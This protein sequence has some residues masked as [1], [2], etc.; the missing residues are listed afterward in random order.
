MKVFLPTFVA[1]LGL[2][3]A[4]LCSSKNATGESVVACPEKHCVHKSKADKCT[5]KPEATCKKEDSICCQNI[6]KKQKETSTTSTDCRITK[7]CRKAEGR[8]ISTD[9]S[10]LTSVVSGS[11]IKGCKCCK[12]KIKQKIS[13]QGTTSCKKRGGKCK[14]K[15]A[16][17][18]KRLRRASCG[19]S[20]VCCATKISSN[21][22]TRTTESCHRAGGHC[23]R[24]EEKCTSEVFK[25]NLCVGTLCDCCIDD[26]TPSDSV[27]GPEDDFVDYGDLYDSIDEVI[28]G[29]IS[30]ESV[31]NAV[32]VLNTDD[33]DELWE[34]D[35]GQ[36][37]HS[38]ESY[39]ND[40]S[41]T[42]EITPSLQNLNYTSCV[43]I[44]S[45]NST[46]IDA[47]NDSLINTS[48]NLNHA[49]VNTNKNDNTSNITVTT[50]ASATSINMNIT[51]PAAN[52]SLAKN[53]S[54]TVADG[55][56]TS[57]NF[58]SITGSS[59]STSFYTNGTLSTSNST[60]PAPETTERS[61]FIMSNA[62]ET[63]R[64]SNP[65]LEFLR[66]HLERP[67]PTKTT[68]TITHEA[69]EIKPSPGYTSSSPGN[70]T[71][72]TLVTPTES[73][74]TF[75][76]VSEIRSARTPRASST[77]N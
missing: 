32:D 12:K 49:S 64:M 54:I 20:C 61:S 2:G 55:T 19:S 68:F 71:P 43:N 27:A 22:C 75:S 53:S 72:L 44:L 24:K 60:S 40:E 39:V 1:I 29:M 23:I 38:N 76:S 63:S 5:K 46:S 59:S 35:S 50:L 9:S 10:C 31:T 52:A 37:N 42:S 17:C 11:C 21:I 51:A 13:C 48:S 58:S 66:P 30:S 70:A 41:G 73:P 18:R 3:L 45:C 62:T 25:K 26:I 65:L 77:P 14:T 34:N 47:M 4:T 28:H 8:C 69:E 36:D 7:K 15:K 67:T 6:E 74:A 16:K 57:L 56:L 33:V